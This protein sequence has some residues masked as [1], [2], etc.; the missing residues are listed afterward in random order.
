MNS[1]FVFKVVLGAVMMLASAS[2]AFAH[3]NVSPAQS[4]QGA[5]EKYTVRV[6]NEKKVDVVR[7]EAEFPVEAGIH[8]LEH[9]PE[10]TVVV[11]K[12]ASGTITTAVWTLNIPP[13]TF[14]EIGVQGINSRTADHVVWKFVQHFADGS[15]ESFTGP[16]G[17]PAPSPITTLMPARAPG[18]AS[19]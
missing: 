17:S 3:I 7:L 14:V 6:P 10:W 18:R 9:K 13:D 1:R 15:K 16:P 4:T 2:L 8:R 11:A 19:H 12:D 5:R